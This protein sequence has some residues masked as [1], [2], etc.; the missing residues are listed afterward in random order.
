MAPFNRVKAQHYRLKN[1]I[2]TSVCTEVTILTWT[3]FNTLLYF[4]TSTSWFLFFPLSEWATDKSHGTG[5]LWNH[6]SK[7]S[8]IVILFCLLNKYY[9]YFVFKC[10]VCAHFSRE[11]PHLQE[12]C[13]AT[14]ARQSSSIPFS[15]CIEHSAPLGALSRFWLG[16][17]HCV[18]DT[19]LLR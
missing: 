4:N 19:M 11:A 12:L 16:R 14:A 6:D 18:I 3:H 2:P 8:S 15:V 5:S 17:L 9:L 10:T 1:K 7:Y 13:L